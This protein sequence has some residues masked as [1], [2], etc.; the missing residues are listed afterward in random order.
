L[1][2]HLLRWLL[3]LSLLALRTGCCGAKGA[4]A[5]AEDVPEPPTLT[6]PDPY[7]PVTPV[8]AGGEDADAGASAR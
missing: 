3:L 8:D 5:T 6:V 4:R 1:T 7:A 2:N